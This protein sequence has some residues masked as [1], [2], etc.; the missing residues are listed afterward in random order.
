M[1]DAS[2]RRKFEALVAAAFIDGYLAEPEKEVLQQK[3]AAMNIPPREMN[4]ILFL[5]Q[6]RKLSVSIPAT[7]LERDALLEDLIDVV[8]AD[9]RVEAPEYHLLARFAETMKIAL[10]D[11]R[12]RVNRRMQG[13]SERNTTADPRRETVRAPSPPP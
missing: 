11:L 7:S 4:D 6:Q 9:G 2:T 13:S 3:A 8:T 12:L 10:P 5:G 1:V